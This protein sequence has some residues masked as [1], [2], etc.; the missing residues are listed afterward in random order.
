MSRCAPALGLGPLYSPDLPSGVPQN[1]S[2]NRFLKGIRSLLSAFS[3]SILR[4]KKRRALYN[5]LS[6]AEAL[7]PA[8]DL[9]KAGVPSME[10]QFT[11]SMDDIDLLDRCGIPKEQLIAEKE[12]L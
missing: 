11:R 4:K 9:Y 1:H 7:A 12:D 6:D 5:A 8:R 3:V 2:L 10:G